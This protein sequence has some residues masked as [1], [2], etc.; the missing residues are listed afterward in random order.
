MSFSKQQVEE[1]SQAI[2]PL[3]GEELT[4]R[5]EA[6]LSVMLSEFARDKKDKTLVALRN[7]FPHEWNKKN[8]KK[9]PVELKKQLGELA[10]LQ[11]EQLIFSLPANGEHP[12]IV[13]IWWPWGHGGTY[14]LRLLIL[15][16]GYNYQPSN[17]SF[18]TKLKQ[19]FS[20]N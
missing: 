12:T 20:P 3:L 18:I 7:A 15:P 14:S 19:M 5:W 4:W 10:K 6:R 13:A 9:S 8:I 16:H 11:K 2:T 17:D 1:I